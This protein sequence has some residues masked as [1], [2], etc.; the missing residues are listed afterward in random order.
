[1]LQWTTFQHWCISNLLANYNKICQGTLFSFFLSN[2]AHGSHKTLWFWYH[3]SFQYQWVLFFSKH[4]SQEYVLHKLQSTRRCQEKTHKPATPSLAFWYGKLKSVAALCSF[5][6]T[7]IGDGTRGVA[8]HGSVVVARSRR[9]WGRP[10]T[11][12][13][14]RSWATRNDLHITLG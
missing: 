6:T 2:A 5:I 13:G 3:A 8:K 1:M 4:S 7:W 9:R 14:G 10:A 11:A 12:F